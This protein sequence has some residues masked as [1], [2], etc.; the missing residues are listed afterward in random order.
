MIKSKVNRK[1][2]IDLSGTQGNAFYVI[3]VGKDLHKQLVKLGAELPAWKD[4]Q[5]EM[6]SKGYENLIQTFDK[7]FGNYCDLER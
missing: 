2:S 5:T 6:M 1:L 7:Y 4:I 3:G